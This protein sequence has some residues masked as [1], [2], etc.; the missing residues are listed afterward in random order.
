MKVV[1][2]VILAIFVLD[3]PDYEEPSD[4]FVFSDCIQVL[5][6]ERCLQCQSDHQSA[7]GC[8][9]GERGKQFRY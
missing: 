7:E 9:T 3:F 6:K 2:F 1:S 4:E 8:Y 5:T